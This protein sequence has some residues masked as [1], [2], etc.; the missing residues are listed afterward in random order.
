MARQ[1]LHRAIERGR[2]FGDNLLDLRPCHIEGRCD[3]YMVTGFAIRG[4]STGVTDQSLG[5]GP[6]LDAGVQLECGGE[7]LLRWTVF[8]DFNGSKQAASANVPDPGMAAKTL[9]Q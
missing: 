5:H 9:P 4:T 1:G 3:Q 8:D 6:L 7:R 2:Q